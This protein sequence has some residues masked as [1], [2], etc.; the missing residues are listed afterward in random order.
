MR[1]R[2][3]T[4]RQAVEVDPPSSSG[5]NLLMLEAAGDCAGFWRFFSGI[6]VTRFVRFLILTIG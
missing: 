5:S 2:V 1:S 6:S 4:E 3:E